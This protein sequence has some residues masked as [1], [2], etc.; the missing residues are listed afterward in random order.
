ME[1]NIASRLTKS[2]GL[3]DRTV[4]PLTDVQ[5]GIW[6]ADHI[7][8]QRNTFTIA[9]KVHIN[10]YLDAKYLLDAIQLG[11][12]EADTI[13]AV[14]RE[15]D[16]VPTQQ[17]ESS[18]LE[19]TPEWMDISNDSDGQAYMDSLIQQDLGAELTLSSTVPL[20]RQI[21]FKVSD[22]QYVW[23]QRFHHIMLDGFS[24]NAFT[25][26][27]ASIYQALNQQKT[28]INSPYAPF[29]QVV[30]E[31]QAY[32]RSDKYQRDKAFWTEYCSDLPNVISLSNR[33]VSADVES[34][35][36]S[37][38]LIRVNGSIGGA[39]LQSCLDR[40]PSSNLTA[41]DL[42][43]GLISAYFIRMS[44]QW[45]VPIGLPFM[46]RV[47]SVSLSSLGPVVNVLPVI[48]E[49]H[50]DD[51][52]FELTRRIKQSLKAIRKHQKYNGEQVSRDLHRVG[53]ALYGPT[54]NLRLFDYD[55]SFGEASAKI[56]H[57]AAGP[58]EDLDVGLHFDNGDL[59][60]EWVGN[61]QKYD[62]EAL[63]Q[64]LQRFE[65]FSERLLLDFDTRIADISTL[66]ASEQ[67]LIQSWQQGVVTPDSHYSSLVEQFHYVD[68]YLATAPALVAKEKSISFA[69]LHEN[70]AKWTQVL[71]DAGVKK[72][73]CV[74]LALPRDERMV[75]AMFA[76]MGLGAHYLPIDPT[77][78]E[79]RIHW[80]LEDSA[81]QLLI[82][83][84]AYDFSVS[85]KTLVLSVDDAGFIQSVDQK[86]PA[87][88]VFDFPS[89][90]DLAYIMYTS[91]STG[92]AKGVVISHKGL[93]NLALAHWTRDGKALAEK[94]SNV[95]AM[96]TASFSFDTCWDAIYWLCYGH[97]LH[98]AEE[99][100][101]KDP[102]LIQQYCYENKIHAT[103]FPPT[104]L[105][106][107]LDL[108]EMESSKSL[109]DL[110]YIG[111]E[112]ASSRLWQQA[113]L[114]PDLKIRNYYG[115][116]ENTVDSLG[117]D[118][119]DS[120][121]VI[122]GRPIANT[123]AYI[124]DSSLSPVAIGMAGELYVAGPGL[125]HGYLNR[126]SL[127]ST[128][129][130][131]N[132][133][134]DGER[135][136]R[137]GDLARWLEDG[138]VEFI[139]RTD[140]Q[141]QI[142]G[143]RVEPGEVEAT[144]N[145]LEGVN[146]SLVVANKQGSTHRLDA[147][148]VLDESLTIGNAQTAQEKSRALMDVLSRQLPAYMVPA[149][150]TILDFFP[151]N[152]N[153][154]VDR[155]ALPAP[156][157]I[158]QDGVLPKGEKEALLCQ[159]V[160]QLLSLDAVFVDDDFF[161][162]GGDSIVAM[163]LGSLARK[164]GYA[165]RAKDI[166]ESRVLSVMTTRLSQLDSIKK[167]PSA[168]SGQLSELPIYKWMQDS[169]GLNLAYFQSTLI[170]LPNSMTLQQFE[171]VISRLISAHCILAAQVHAS[172]LDISPIANAFPVKAFEKQG[173]LSQLADDAFE[174]LVR[175]ESSKAF[176]AMRVAYL[177]ANNQNAA[178]F[179][180]HHTIVDGVSWRILFS[181]LSNLLKD[182]NGELL[183]PPNSLLDWQQSLQ[184]ER[185][186]WLSEKQ[187]WLGQLQG[188]SLFKREASKIRVHHR[189]LLDE[190]TSRLLL[191]ILPKQY[192]CQPQEALLSALY[193]A[194][195][196][197]YRAT[198]IPLMME[199]HG[200]ADIGDMDLTRT[201][202]WFTSEYPVR[203]SGKKAL[204]SRLLQSMNMS[205]TESQETLSDVPY[206][207]IVQLVRRALLRVPN[208]G[209]GYGVLRYLE[210]STREIFV[211]QESAFSP[212]ILFNYLGRFQQ[213]DVHLL[214]GE[215]YF[216]DTFEVHQSEQL[217][218][219]YALELNVFVDDSHGE[220]QLA[221]HIGHD[222]QQVTAKEIEQLLSRLSCVTSSMHKYADTHQAVAADTLVT[223]DLK[224][225]DLS[226]RNID[227]L[228]SQYGAL[229]TIL[230]ALPLQEGLL[231]HAQL[232]HE[233]DANDAGYSS[234]ARLTFTGRMDV[235]R[236]KDALG[237]VIEKHPQLGALFDFSQADTVLQILPWR[238][239]SERKSWWPVQTIDLSD[240]GDAEQQVQ[241]KDIERQELSRDFMAFQSTGVP[242][243]NA[244]L[245]NLSDQR[246]C[247]FLNAHHLVVDGWSTPIMLR[248]LVT[249]YGSDS[250]ELANIPVPYS[251]VVEQL[252]SR[253]KQAMQE[254]WKAALDGASPTLLFADTP[255]TEAVITYT[256]TIETDRFSKL[257]SLYQRRGLTLNSVLQT[258]WANV[259]S[260][261]TGRSDVVFGTPISGRF[262]GVTGIEEHIGLFS[263]TVPVRVQLQPELSVWQQMQQVQI[264]Q[265]DL[266]EHD[267]L[268]LAEIQ[269]L[270]G[271][272]NLFDTLFVVENF[273]EQADLFRQT[274]HGLQLNE[275]YN[276]GFTHYPLTVLA[277]PAEQLN[278]LFEYRGGD[279]IKAL[280]T[281]FE[282]LLNGL[283]EEEESDV[284]QQA[285][286]LRLPSEKSL[287]AEL[288]QTSQ[289]VPHMTLGD[290]LTK[291]AFLTPNQLCLSDDINQLSYS[292]AR[293]HVIALA[294]KLQ[295]LGV[296]SGDIV[297]VAL[298]R[299][300]KLSLALWATIEVGAAY[301]PL[302]TGYPDDRLNYMLDDAKPVALIT[303][304]NEVDRFETNARPYLYDAPI[305]VVD[306][307]QVKQTFESWNAPELSQSAAAY[308]LYTSGSTGRPKGV[309]VSHQAIVNRIL[310][311][312]NQYPLTSEDVVLQKTPCSFDVSVWEFFWSA[313][314]GAKLHMA[315]PDSHRD[316]LQLQQ[317]I[318]DHKITI[319]HFVPSM[320]AAFV[321]S[322]GDENSAICHSLKRVFCSGEALPVELS[323]QFET[324]V[325]CELHNL[326]GPTEAAVDV[327]Y[328]PVFGNDLA[329]LKG[330]G[331]P[332]GYPVWNTQLRILDNF[333]RPVPIGV[334]GELY[335]CG[336]QLA[337]GYW[338]RPELCATRFVADPE[339][340]GER[341]YRTGDVVR[342]L[343]SGAVEYLG[344][345]DDQL[346]IR[347]QRIELGEIEQVLAAQIGVDQ[348][349]VVAKTLGQ[350]NS[351][352][353]ADARQL[354]AYVTTHS[355]ELD[356]AQIRTSM[357]ELLPAHMVPVSVLQ[358]EAMPLSANGKL[359]R[360]A[361]PL[362]SD[363]LH[364]TK[365][366]AVRLGIET[367]IANAF[368]NVLGL[369]GLSASDDFFTLG[370][371]SILAV[372]L[373]A[374]LRKALKL[375][376]TVGQVM[377]SP[378]IEKLAHV[379]SNQDLA[380]SRELSG[381]GSVLPIKQGTGSPIFCIH[382]AS[383]F[384][385]Q[386]TGFARYLS[387]TCPMIGLQSPRPDG[388]IA[389]QDNMEG[390]VEQ[391]LK[392]LKERQPAGP[393]RL[394]G[395]S[396]GGAIAH[397]LAVRLQTMGEEVSFLGLLDTYP[398]DEQDWSGSVDEEA[399]DE[400]E[401][402]KAQ[403]METSEDTLD[404]QMEVERDAMFADIVQN[405]AD[406][407]ALLS[408]A[409]T[410]RYK[411]K[412]VL[413]VADKTLPEGMDIQA[414]WAP[415]VD[416]LEEHHFE[417]AHEDILSPEALVVLGPVFDQLI[418]Q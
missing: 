327:T 276:R 182:P 161:A 228:R 137:T 170:A 95:N 287:I 189:T 305:A 143:H 69:Q 303:L 291:Q 229:Q 342:W 377:V 388:P 197:Q 156:V 86:D 113:R 184:N 185:A 277:L 24:F 191:D 104:V 243:L 353:G 399:Q 415:Y 314:V 172:Y 350:D 17:L 103:D 150:L 32:K 74:G 210:D 21:V 365:G 281:R 275:V 262:S 301:L 39:I 324:K 42:A 272:N 265:V 87:K 379:L 393:Y 128:R 386:Y 100:T 201:L 378:S 49:G 249:A 235:E 119:N 190:N 177:K 57:L 164:H 35:S 160:Q 56:E 261:L 258:L 125:A 306:D 84:D 373:V 93:V 236:L 28:I 139:G 55:L 3:A 124:L 181:D 411:G 282:T 404:K 37:Q 339:A 362:P 206:E 238:R 279:E 136:Y 412:A 246:H 357:S 70:I 7:S 75:Y 274:Y 270:G 131:A 36:V 374:E 73:A 349:V 149:T 384:A 30:E 168:Q 390:V 296:Q 26:R 186:L 90:D 153:G 250:V 58:V 142:R 96:L 382:P 79:E 295:S 257:K 405:Y 41:A 59:H 325:G 248:D 242:L 297:A 48:I 194:L 2:I 169:G 65:A 394:I 89:S 371:H 25:A 414:T 348:S 283:L 78:P 226:E 252:V 319:L 148:A 286:D 34:V 402:E 329:Q 292:E 146:N 381:F 318:V 233:G 392:V 273:P 1:N 408:K 138:Q 307:S 268:G 351:A 320:L 400:V 409:K 205:D 298:P 52:I 204:L 67:L 82:T 40:F 173:G 410:E 81:P 288:N 141:V 135:M 198:D 237:A 280:M 284:P 255:P 64:H 310:W 10:G 202:G 416:S 163:S 63:N 145:D 293:Y 20:V 230:P 9:H 105:S 337:D 31:E 120:D 115:P 234:L 212:Q 289:R 240:Q 109:P 317:L 209:V 380:N 193:C 395:Y 114:R 358:L 8:S 216:Q 217:N 391:H 345:S 224:S 18:D 16:G 121:K 355:G 176:P 308:L 341:M 47:G 5:M 106:Q 196:Q 14:Y 227:A 102:A 183:P 108:D 406:S 368:S 174:Q 369:T 253:D 157:T 203:L 223:E 370:G 304:S 118:V 126:Y 208:D 271:H 364:S 336:V 360:K 29:Y 359:D 222:A 376:V 140:H 407:V 179:A 343:D 338:R 311:M 158:R 77:Y 66:L 347:G 285:L 214:K 38:R 244:V 187:Y 53:E 101:C 88:A 6:L 213:D 97:T 367:E 330:V 207:A 269:R 335:L 361:L 267:G 111:G 302:D 199:S 192:R 132:P 54:L 98:I 356:T 154:K 15:Y 200:R 85:D 225:L 387:Q 363:V 107:L 333:L 60:I 23:Y 72:G 239:T 221:I 129:F 152:T 166:F 19:F 71:S 175:I 46:G 398:P 167:L 413:F 299:S 91:G 383:G 231:F 266:L 375:N 322:L 354:V 315:P 328:F 366:R 188:S 418:S 117:S 44:G 165:L 417:F 332:I 254:A 300:V 278:L 385:W 331:V 403:F 389:A 178:V 122:I 344:R 127:T 13:Q 4:A 401:R 162:L 397:G 215:R 326:Y 151:L 134:K 112:A 62:V 144:L 218:S 290:S 294:R 321:S 76:A 180:L 211:E 247:L 159:W 346:K 50:L 220:A 259:L 110:M 372:R 147:Y 83:C 61:D 256:L 195:V 312:Q 313:M 232:E 27:V 94:H 51:G 323:K 68:S 396:L 251:W 45:R 171:Q 219:A 155:K 33:E 260:G 99:E 116:T 92:K 43:M 352:M 22:Q 334:A 263:N 12:N 123:Q 241:L 130:V 11:L 245:V 309:L 80:M 316:P 133:F 340:N 264:E